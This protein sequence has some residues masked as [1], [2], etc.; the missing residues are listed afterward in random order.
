[1]HVTELFEAGALEAE[2]E[3]GAVKRQVHPT[4]PLAIYN[5]SDVCQYRRM[6]NPVNAQ[7]RGLIIDTESGEV[8]ARPFPKF[9][10]YTETAMPKFALNSPPVVF[11][12]L[13]GSLGICYPDDT[14]PSGHAV[15]TRG[16]F[17]SE[18]A[19]W[20]TAHLNDRWPDFAPRAGVTTLWEIVYP[21][22]RIVVNYGDRAELVLLAAIEVHTG[23][24][25]PLWEVDWWPGSVVDH[26]G[27]MPHVDD[28]Y[29]HGT[30][31]EYESLEG[32]VAVWYR[33]D[34]ESFRL[35]IKHP[36]Y[37]RL[38]RI[39]SSLSN[40][41]VWETLSR[42]ESMEQVILE[43]GLPDECFEWV[44][45][46][47]DTLRAQYAEQRSTALADFDRIMESFDEND[48]PTG[49]K[50]RRR[51]A[52]QAKLTKYPHLVFKLLD[53]KDITEMVWKG[54]YPEMREAWSGLE[55]E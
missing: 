54:C 17:A 27:Q 20:A 37:V 30:S 18:Q 7:C 9:F 31:N 11:D 53:G 36:E 50:A 40:R 24:D 33:P 44:R 8:I 55:A 48:P 6:W 1:M 3:S 52:E 21:E 25:V 16:S 19:A 46:W 35:K 23:L 34:Q 14:Q 38:H 15:A 12:K 29:R 43:S 26:L 41:A 45:K 39:V 49:G 47:E 13:D 5:Y 42:G 32:V 28:A 22:N 2:V 51:F 4:R 10:N